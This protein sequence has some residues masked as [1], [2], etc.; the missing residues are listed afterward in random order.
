MKERCVP[1]EEWFLEDSTILGE[2]ESTVW[3]M[4]VERKVFSGRSRFQQVDIFD[5]R[6]YGRVLALDGLV[7]LST[8]HES[9]YH[10]MLVHP[11]L[12]HAPDPK[13][14]LIIG[15]GDGGA[16]RE[17]VKHPLQEILLVDIDEEVVKLSRR[18]LP[19]LSNGAFDDRRVTLVHADA[20]PLLR[21][22][23]NSFDI[24]IS[25]CTDSYGPSKALWSKKFYGFILQALSAKGVAGFQTGYFKERYARKGRR[26]IREVFPFSLVYRAHVGC[27][28]FDECAFTI[29]SKNVDFRKLGLRSLEMKF[30]KS[31]IQTR[32]YSP[33]MHFAST[34]IPESF[35][36][37]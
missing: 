13:K 17:L 16:L 34:V 1:G 9:V 26:Q 24:I 33:E 28:P 11:A 25:D 30:R 20:F 18:F 7:Q 15:G 22:H 35:G 3:G 5:T 19:S 14:A 6:E 32:Y 23:K 37:G 21:K 12:F 31:D 10:E 2:P 8:R 4:L 29:A 27:F 36:E